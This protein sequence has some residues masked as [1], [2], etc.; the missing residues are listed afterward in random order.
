MATE[1]IL[2]A[3][4]WLRVSFECGLGLTHSVP[5]EKENSRTSNV[6]DSLD[7][8]ILSWCAAQDL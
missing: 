2:G 1:E 4:E 5:M 6:V 8:R 7:E 3:S